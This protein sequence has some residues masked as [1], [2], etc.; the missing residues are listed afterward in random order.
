[1]FSHLHLGFNHYVILV[2]LKEYIV[3]HFFIVFF[4]WP[5]SDYYFFSLKARDYSH[6]LGNSFQTCIYGLFQLFSF[7]G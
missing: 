5:C 1:M 2:L 4:P 7:E 6:L 3:L